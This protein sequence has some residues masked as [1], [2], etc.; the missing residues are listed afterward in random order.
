LTEVLLQRECEA[1]KNRKQI[2]VLENEVV[3]I[4]KQLKELTERENAQMKEYLEKQEELSLSTAHAKKIQAE[5]KSKLSLCDNEIEKQHALL[6]QVQNEAAEREHCHPASENDRLSKER[7][8][9]LPSL[10]ASKNQRKGVEDQLSD[11]TGKLEQQLERSATL[12]NEAATLNEE[13]SPRV[14]EI[15][16]V[17]EERSA[18]KSKLSRVFKQLAEGLQREGLQKGEL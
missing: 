17:S 16:L 18:L 6:T 15:G 4:L 12:E 8:S 5:L 14:S 9:T 11:S 7:A 13:I 3:D 10:A 1:E 2:V